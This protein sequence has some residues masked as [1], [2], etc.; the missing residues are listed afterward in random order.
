MCIG[1]IRIKEGWKMAA[2]RIQ[3]LIFS[4]II[5]PEKGMVRSRKVISRSNHG[6]VYKFSSIKCGRILHLESGNEYNLA[7]IYEFDHTVIYF[8]EQPFKLEYSDEDE[9]KTCFP[10]FLV[11]RDDGSMTVEEVKNETEVNKSE[12]E[13]KFKLEKNALDQHGYFKRLIT[14]KLFFLL[15]AFTSTSC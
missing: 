14:D 5:F 9:I 8:Q 2:Y 12:N 10:D 13:Q 11:F 6:H 4:R 7:N 3:N 15:M 1:K